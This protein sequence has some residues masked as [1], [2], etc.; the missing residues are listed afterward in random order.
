[1]VTVASF[2]RID[3]GEAVVTAGI[4][5]AFVV[6]S[7]LYEVSGWPAVGAVAVVCVV[8]AAGGILAE[9][10]RE[11][12]RDR[13]QLHTGDT[14]TVAMV[15]LVIVGGIFGAQVATELALHVMSDH[16]LASGVVFAAAAGVAVLGLVVYRL[17]RSGTVGGDDDVS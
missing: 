11:R 1:V 15:T 16:L 13:G 17:D 9:A 12:V 8:L 5:L 6:L 14:L 3:P 2:P 10:Y 4:L 7:L